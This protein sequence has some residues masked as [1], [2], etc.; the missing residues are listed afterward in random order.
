MA[1]AE[2]RNRL[3]EQRRLDERENRIQ[4]L[5]DMRGLLSEMQ[6]SASEAMDSEE[7]LAVG[8]IERDMDHIIGKLTE[9]GDGFN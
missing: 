6:D 5:R 2:H 4:M 1:S 3:A 8:H 9:S 7:Q